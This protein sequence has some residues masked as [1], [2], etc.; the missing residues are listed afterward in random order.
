MPAPALYELH[1]ASVH[2]PQGRVLAPLEL[3]LRDHAVTALVGPVGSGK[4]TLLRLLSGRTLSEGWVIGGQWRH[5]GQALSPAARGDAPLP[6]VAWL[7]QLRNAPVD[8]LAPPELAAARARLEGALSCGARVV[9]LDEPE[10]GLPDADREALVERLRALAG[11]GAAIVVSHDLRF[12]REVAD[13]VCLLCDGELVAQQPARE[14]FEQPEQV[15]VEQF[16]REGTCSLPPSIPGLPRHFHWFEPL[17][18]LAPGRLA[19]MGRP[20]LLRDMDDDLFAIAHAGVTLLVSL[21]EDPLPPRRLRPFGIEGRH[22]PIR[23]MGIPGMSDTLR[24]CHDLRRA[25]QRGQRVAVHCLAGLGRTGT[26]LACLGVCGGMS[27]AQAI[28][29]VRRAAP[30]SIQTEQQAM[31]VHE[32]E[33][34]Q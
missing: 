3:V 30:G 20:G 28:D 10:R 6:D 2:G 7:P 23:D 21:T 18:G 14:F 26:I 1:Q 31:F 15:L 19:G 29:A 13:E 5:R 25:L 16:V 27:A 8:G 9:L 11:S 17:P 22:F 34:R 33:A 32:L 24:L 4:S 12:T